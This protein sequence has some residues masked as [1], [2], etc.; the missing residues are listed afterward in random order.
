ML[1]NAWKWGDLK[2]PKNAKNSTFSEFREIPEKCQIPGILGD[3]LGVGFWEV[4]EIR[5]RDKPPVEFEVSSLQ[6]AWRIPKS[7]LFEKSIF[8]L[9]KTAEGK[10][11]HSENS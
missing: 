5:S 3:I 11:V 10:I 1:L 6:G 7:A 4:I 2:M 9:S 8:I